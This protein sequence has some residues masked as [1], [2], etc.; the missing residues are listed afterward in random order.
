M[1][2]ALDRADQMLEPFSLDK[3]VIIISDGVLGTRSG[4]R[5]ILTTE[6]VKAMADKGIT[7]YT[8]GVGFDTDETFMADLAK[9]G[10]GLYFKPE[11]YE[12][13]KMAFEEKDSQKNLDRYTLDIYNKY[14]FITRNVELPDTSIKDYN[15]VTP[16]SISQVLVNNRRA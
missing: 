7:V 9:T 10:N 1:L 3:Y 16:K 8:V 5:S 4:S 14:H 13:L 12:R 11:A 2:P 15:D 6:K